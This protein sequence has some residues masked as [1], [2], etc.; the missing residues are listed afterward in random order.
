LVAAALNQNGG[1][2]RLA[3]AATEIE[4]QVTGFFAQ[5]FGLPADTAGGTVVSGGALATLSAL[6][7]ARDQCA[8][9]DVVHHGVPTDASLA[10]YAS[11]ET[12]A[13]VWRAADVLGLGRQA[14]HVVPVDDRQRMHVPSLQTMIERDIADGRRPVA[15]VAT[16]GTTATGA[17]DPLPEIADV[18]RAHALWM[19]VD[20][21]YGGAAV[22]SSTLAP[23]LQGIEWADSIAFDA[24][25][26]MGVPLGAGIVLYRTMAAAFD[27]FHVAA[28]YTVEDTDRSGS[29]FDYGSHG[30]EWS[31]AFAA[32]KLWLSL[33]AHG[34]QTW[35]E[36]IDHDVA[37]TQYLAA[38][39]DEHPAFELVTP[40][41]LSICC[42][43]H[44][45][46]GADDETVDQTN[47]RLMT[48][49]QLG[50]RSYCSNAIV[51]GRFALRT[52]IVNF[53]TESWHVDQLI[54][55]LVALAQTE[56]VRCGSDSPRL[57]S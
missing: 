34:H 5:R 12:H 44:L 6:K 26:W 27:S 15:V 2:F 51:D 17:I 45:V 52:C 42:F 32:L 49:S 20:A 14:V 1:G 4:R 21:A 28:S 54:D 13:V 39:I 23:R 37:L 41:S 46:P 47:Y 3:P 10:I 56:W 43:R 57:T 55:D 31:R 7:V 36:R 50:G 53:R 25:K 16:A 8:G 30:L 33:M 29:T 22:L 35:G 18:C 11:T 24:H 9:S 48:A 19:H 38:R 40:P